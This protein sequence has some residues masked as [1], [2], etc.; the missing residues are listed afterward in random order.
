MEIEEE[1][2]KITLGRYIEKGKERVCLL[3]PPR[4]NIQS[5]C[6]DDFKRLNHVRFTG[7]LT[8]APAIFYVTFYNIP[9]IETQMKRNVCIYICRDVYFVH[10]GNDQRDIEAGVYIMRMT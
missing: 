1:K 3:V 10:R 2:K 8:H 4:A 7:K 5:L 6:G 9:Y